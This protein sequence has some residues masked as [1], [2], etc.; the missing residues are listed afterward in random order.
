LNFILK[1]CYNEVALPFSLRKENFYLIKKNIDKIE[2]RI[3]SLEDVLEDGLKI[4]AF[5][6]SD[7]FEYMSYESMSEVYK[8][9]IDSA[10]GGARVVYWN[11]LVDRK[12][13]KCFLDKV[14]RDEKKCKEFLDRDKAFF[15]S[16]FIIELIVTIIVICVKG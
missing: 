16:K 4:D 7:I 3:T 10:S 8:K 11:M 9:I 13:P 2:F 1:G 15:Y 5:N 6:L 12:C 14:T